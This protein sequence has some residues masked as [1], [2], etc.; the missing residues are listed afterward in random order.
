MMK[1]HFVIYVM[2]FSILI[3]G[4]TFAFIL[5]VATNND[6]CFVVAL[7]LFF[8]GL[9]LTVAWARTSVPAR[10]LLAGLLCL[11]LFMGIQYLRFQYHSALMMERHQ[12]RVQELMK[13]K[14]AA[15]EHSLDEC[16][17]QQR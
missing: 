7:A 13:E 14:T 1:E 10:W 17:E 15:E 9:L 2:C 3:G 16:H 12:E 11:T 6:A 8:A 4:S 5:G